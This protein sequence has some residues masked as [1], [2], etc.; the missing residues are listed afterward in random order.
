VANAHK[1]PRDRTRQAMREQA[2][3]IAELDKEQKIGEQTAGFQR[4]AEVKN[5]EAGRCG[6]SWPNADARAVEGENL[7]KAAIAASQSRPAK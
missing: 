2:V 4:E 7:A 5:A 6:S 3:R 1:V